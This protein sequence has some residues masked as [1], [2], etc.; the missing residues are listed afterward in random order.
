[1]KRTLIASLLVGAAAPVLAQGSV[2]IYGVI[3]AAVTSTKNGSTTTTALLSGVGKGSR[4]G[5]KGNEDLGGGLSADFVLENGFVVDTGTVA[6]GGVFFGRY[7][8]VGLSS[9]E[10]WSLTA[11]RQD[12][13]LTTSV[14]IS[15]P[16]NWTYFGNTVSA[17]LGVFESPSE[18]PTSAGWQANSRVNNSLLGKYTFGPVSAQ[19]MRGFGNENTAG[20]GELWSGSLTYS[21]GPLMVTGA[22]G[23]SKQF[24]ASITPGATAHTQ[25]QYVLGAYYD[26]KLAKV[27]AGYY[28]L[29]A[30]NANKPAG[31]PTALDPR[32]DKYKTYWIGARVPLPVGVLLTNLMKSTYDYATKSQGAGVTLGV[33]YEYSLSK[34][35]ALYT[36][37]GQVNNNAN[38]LVALTGAIPFIAPSAA[39]TDLHALALGVRHSF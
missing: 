21:S 28:Q 8:F 13:P 1:M 16:L 26:F 17:G 31:S 15:D 18:G 14:I 38:G 2:T 5:F 37:Y 23:S 29:D 6:Q 4:L 9:R 34:R 35:T 27:S 3:D 22:Y 19:L 12:S 30:F 11:G 25:T 7:A 10:G 33:T 20:N 24:A 32:G 36:S 39:G